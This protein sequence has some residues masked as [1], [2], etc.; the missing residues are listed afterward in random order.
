[1]AR[2]PFEAF[3]S[4]AAVPCHH[5]PCPLAVH[6]RPHPAP[7]GSHKREPH[8]Q[9]RHR[10]A[11]PQG[12][13]PLT[14]PL[15]SRRVA[16]AGSPDASMGF[17]DPELGPRSPVRAIGGFAPRRDATMSAPM[18]RTE[19]A[20]SW[21]ATTS[22]RLATIRPP[23]TKTTE[24]RGLEPDPAHPTARRRC[25][26]EGEHWRPRLATVR[27]GANEI[28]F[29]FRLGT[30]PG[31]SEERPVAADHRIRSDFALRRF[32]GPEASPSAS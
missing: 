4:P 23:E 8:V 7:R 19:S 13:A 9:S 15:Q 3:P 31:R 26:P 30:G 17:R 21:Q 20:K 11:R 14:N 25:A 22:S 2:L 12:F 18:P 1:M 29:Q 28:G 16:T 32:D 6:R 24:N 5:G 10:A 27:T